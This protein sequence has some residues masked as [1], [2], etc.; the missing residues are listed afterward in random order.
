MLWFEIIGFVGSIASI[1]SLVIA[2]IYLPN[3][4]H[5]RKVRKV[6]NQY[7]DS[8]LLQNNNGFFTDFSSYYIRAN[9][10][11]REIIHSSIKY[12]PKF[13]KGTLMC[14]M[15]MID[16]MEQLDKEFCCCEEE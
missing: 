1:A 10:E 7:I 2:I 9:K 14:I 16:N 15:N 6:Y 11:E 12:A 8:G 4:I 3:L 13:H 5:W